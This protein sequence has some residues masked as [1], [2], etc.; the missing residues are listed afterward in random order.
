MSS[1]TRRPSTSQRAPVCTLASA[2][3]NVFAFFWKEG[4]A[5]PAAFDGP[6]AARRICPRGHGLGLDGVFLLDDPRGGSPWGMEHWDADGSRSF[7]SNGARAAAALLPDGAQGPTEIRCSGETALLDRRGAE[8]GL[9]LP[10]GPAFGLADAPKGLPFPAVYAWTGTPQLVMEAPDIDSIDLGTL[11]PPLRF[12]PELPSGANVSL[13]QVL[14]PGLAKVRTWER[15]VEGET[16]S[17]GQAAA[18]AAAWLAER[19]GERSWEVRPKGRDALRL[20]IG[21][22]QGRRWTGLWLRGPV[23]VLGDIALGPSLRT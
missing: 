22:L 10:Q 17:C 23:R 3:G 8:V 12:H 2:S 4:Q 19:T 7:C 14:S 21:G 5:P 6:G 20:D 16:Q 15:G 18:A 1:A 9:R 11:A 13:L